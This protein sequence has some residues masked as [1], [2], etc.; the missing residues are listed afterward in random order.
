[1]IFLDEYKRQSFLQAGII[2][3]TDH[4][5]KVPEIASL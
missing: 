1:M 2:I 3:F 5:H 4:S